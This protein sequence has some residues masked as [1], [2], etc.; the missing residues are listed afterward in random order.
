MHQEEVPFH[1]Q[2]LDLIQRRV[3]ALRA[4]REYVVVGIAGGSASG[5]GYIT[6]RLTPRIDG[7]SVLG[8]DH[9]YLSYH[10]LP[11][12]GNF[13]EPGALELDLFAEHLK[14]LRQGRP[15]E[16]PIY[17]FPTSSRLAAQTTRIEPA[18]VLW[19]DGLFALHD[20]V[21][22]HVDFGIFVHAS[23][24]LRKA[25]RVA[26]DTIE[27]R[28]LLDGPGNSYWDSCVEPGYQKYIAPTRAYAHIVVVN[29][30]PLS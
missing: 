23:S 21:R 15:I 20:L 3:E 28:N 2:T 30:A 17:H 14:E 27:G 25:R 12:P 19:V 10:Q 16:R 26:R 24:E 1:D 6:E 18:P 29:E 7:I 22:P 5:K 9:Y 11:T 8:L 4:D 13:D